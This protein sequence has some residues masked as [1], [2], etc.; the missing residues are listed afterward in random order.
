MSSSTP[1]YIST[2]GGIGSIS[3]PSPTG[4]ADINISSPP[5]QQSLESRLADIFNENAPS[6]DRGAGSDAESEGGGGADES[7][8]SSG[9]GAPLDIFNA[10]SRKPSADG[11]AGNSGGF[12]PGLGGDHPVTT[13]AA[14]PV[15]TIVA[16]SVDNSHQQQS[17]PVI[18][19]MSRH[20]RSS[21]YDGSSTPTQ[22]E[23]TFASDG[24]DDPYADPFQP[25]Y[26]TG[27]ATGG[28]S[29]NGNALS[30]LTS[31]MGNATKTPLLRPV[32]SSESTTPPVSTPTSLIPP[33]PETTILPPPSFLTTPPPTINA[34]SAWPGFGS[35]TAPTHSPYTP[36]STAYAPSIPALP[37][38]WSGAVPQSP[39]EAGR[40][41]STS[42]DHHDETPTKRK[43]FSLD[44]L[45]PAPPG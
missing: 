17:I 36:S 26:S 2:P 45:Q 35:P 32:S 28:S 25:K 1:D 4:S 11:G 34:A 40:R 38:P 5:R 33:Q 27:G 10:L 8:N 21:N 16:P 30:F 14:T 41:G 15:A 24:S 22:D 18:S 23:N 12:L 9:Q 6:D 37:A 7:K 39:V 43:R 29:F 19:S 31:F 20:S 44:Q 13:G 3:P 42:R